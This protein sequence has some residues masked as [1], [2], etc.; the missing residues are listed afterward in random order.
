M[1]AIAAWTNWQNFSNCRIASSLVA[2]T[3]KEAMAVLWRPVTWECLPLTF[4]RLWFM[5]YHQV[6]GT[7]WWGRG[8][9]V[10]TS[11]TRQDHWQH[12]VWTIQNIPDGEQFKRGKFLRYQA[13]NYILMFSTLPP[14]KV[15]NKSRHRG[16]PNKVQGSSIF[17]LAAFSTRSQWQWRVGVKIGHTT[18]L[19]IKMEH[20]KSNWSTTWPT[21]K[22]N[23][24]R[25]QPTWRSLGQRR[26]SAYWGG[27]GRRGGGLASTQAWQG[28]SG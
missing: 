11:L 24:P 2:Q 28:R 27:R 25:A 7:S 15:G 3:A 19:I 18:S 12:C 8:G 23:W 9:T 5:N 1:K 17:S 20:Y 22:S 13:K 21:N 6:M 16:S 14:C 26:G 4:S 10:G